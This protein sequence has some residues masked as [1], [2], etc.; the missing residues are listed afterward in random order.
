MMTAP[1]LFERLAP[2][3]GPTLYASY[4]RRDLCI[5]ATRL[6]VRVAAHFGIR[7]VRR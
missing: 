3:V 1:E 2:V 7:E 6:V 4:G 5:L